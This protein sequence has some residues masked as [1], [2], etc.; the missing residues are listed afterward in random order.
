MAVCVVVGK[1]GK[2]CTDRSRSIK[3]RLIIIIHHKIRY[4]LI[5]FI[6]FSSRD[7]TSIKNFINMTLENIYRRT[8]RRPSCYIQQLHS[9]NSSFIILVPPEGYA[10]HLKV[11][12]YH[13]YSFSFYMQLV[14]SVGIGKGGRRE[15]RMLIRTKMWMTGGCSNFSSAATTRLHLTCPLHLPLSRQPTCPP[16]MHP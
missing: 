11:V 9:F 8:R 12:F 3:N 13:R 6:Y 5:T 1:A 14:L 2:K 7:V 16:S 15:E 4:A 10:Q